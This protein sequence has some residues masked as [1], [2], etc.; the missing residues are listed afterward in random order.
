MRL[1]P[2]SLVSGPRTLSVQDPSARGR[3]FLSLLLLGEN[4]RGD[5]GLKYLES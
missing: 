4:Q 1:T 5:L 3:K 2:G